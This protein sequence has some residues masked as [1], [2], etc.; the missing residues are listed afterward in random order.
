MKLGTGSNSNNKSELDKYLAEET[1]DTEMKLDLLVWWKASEQRFPIL[2]RL[3]RDVL[4]IPIS[5]VASESAFSTGGRILDDFR[6][7][8]TPF[9]LEALVCT[10]DWLR[11]TIPV[12]I[13]EN[14]EELTKL[15]E[16][17]NLFLSLLK[18]FNWSLHISI[19]N[20]A[21]AYL[22]VELFEEF[23]KA[24][25]AASSKTNVTIK[26]GSNSIDLGTSTI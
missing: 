3:A 12:D 1:E 6:S 23:G 22:I 18:F 20:I 13:T 15:E 26:I 2:S 7:S 24:K 11:W 4:A 19:T 9:M 8:L 14:I 21:L 5:S 17:I 16:G 25:Q 10:Q